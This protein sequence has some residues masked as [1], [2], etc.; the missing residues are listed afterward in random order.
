MK[1]TLLGKGNLTNLTI[2]CE[3]E[4]FDVNGVLFFQDDIGNNRACEYHEWELGE[5]EC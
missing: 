1:R 5:L 4:T 3:Y 2:N